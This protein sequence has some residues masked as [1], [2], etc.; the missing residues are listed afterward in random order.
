MIPAVTSHTPKNERECNARN[1]QA[2]EMPSISPY[3]NSAHERWNTSVSFYEQAL[4]NSPN[5]N[6]IEC[7][8]F[9]KHGRL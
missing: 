9:T 2:N 3:G 1:G 8:N 4:H 7:K 5:P 6:T